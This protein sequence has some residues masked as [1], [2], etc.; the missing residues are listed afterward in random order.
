MARTMFEL[1]ND[2][3]VDIFDKKA[4]LEMNEHPDLYMTHNYNVCYSCGNDSIVKSCKYMGINYKFCD[5]CWGGPVSY[6]DDVGEFIEYVKEWQLSDVNRLEKM[7]HNTCAPGVCEE[8]WNSFWTICLNEEERTRPA[9]WI[10]M[11]F[12]RYAEMVD[13]YSDIAPDTPDGNDFVVDWGDEDS[14]VDS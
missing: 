1:P 5:F 11:T 13:T 10:A 8:T 14:D 4:E 3:L 2:L 12:K 7:Y 6:A 9:E